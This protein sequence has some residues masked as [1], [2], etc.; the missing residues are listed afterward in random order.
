MNLKR[1][2][3][4][5]ID[6]TSATRKYEYKYRI[7]IQFASYLQITLVTR[8]IRSWLCREYQQ[9]CAERNSKIVATREKRFL[10]HVSS[11]TGR[12]LSQV[13]PNWRRHDKREILVTSARIIRVLNVKASRAVT[14]NKL[15]GDNE[16]DRRPPTTRRLPERKKKR[17]RKE[18]KVKNQ[19]RNDNRTL[20]RW[21]RENVIYRL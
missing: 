2:I 18:K 10:F 20:E 12:S 4:L 6:Y 1:L 9:N 8:A 14:F 17:R 11:N 5:F 16:G 7:L 19:G 3:A 21:N 13:E 15:A